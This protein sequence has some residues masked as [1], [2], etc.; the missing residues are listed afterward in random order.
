MLDL[1]AL[2]RQTADLAEVD[3]AGANPMLDRHYYGLSL[4]LRITMERLEGADDVPEEDRECALALLSMLSLLDRAQTPLSLLSGHDEDDVLEWMIEACRDVDC[5]PLLSCQAKRMM[6]II[7]ILSDDASL[8]RARDLC[9]RYGL[10]QD[11]GGGS[12]IVVGIMHQLMQ[13]YLRHATVIAT[14][15]RRVVVGWCDSRDAVG[16]LHLR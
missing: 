15:A 2:F 4:S 12:N 9:V 10:F 6:G 8:E 16:A 11:A 5:D 7:R 1:I 14:P 13:R 3:R